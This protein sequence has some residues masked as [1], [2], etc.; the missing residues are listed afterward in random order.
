MAMH[1]WGQGIYGKS[2]HLPLSCVVNLKRVLKKIKSLK[3][4]KENPREIE[5]LISIIG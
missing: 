5:G 2:L 1:V 4:Q 3:N